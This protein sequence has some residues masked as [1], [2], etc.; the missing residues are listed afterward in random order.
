MKC[1]RH[2]LKAVKSEPYFDGMEYVMVYHC[3]A[4]S[5]SISALDICL[6]I[7]FNFRMDIVDTGVHMG[8]VKKTIL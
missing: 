2:Y 1:W 5:D 3:D 8:H 4:L 6:G 7:L